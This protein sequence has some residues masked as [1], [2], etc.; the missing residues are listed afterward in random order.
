M[1]KDFKNEAFDLIH[2]IAL[3]AQNKCEEPIPN[4]I[5]AALNEIVALARY[6]GS[7][8]NLISKPRRELF[9]LD[10]DE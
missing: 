2:K 3:K 4:I 5:E 7:H 6:K 9:D 1:S 8:G 10:E